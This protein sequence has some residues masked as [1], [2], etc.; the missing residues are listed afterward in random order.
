MWNPEDWAAFT[1]ALAGTDW[2]PYVEE[3]S[4]RAY[5]GNLTHTNM[6][7]GMVHIESY[8][9]KLVTDY[10]TASNGTSRITID[11]ADWAATAKRW[12]E[13]PGARRLSAWNARREEDARKAAAVAAVNAR[14]ESLAAHFVSAGLAPWS[15]LISPQSLTASAIVDAGSLRVEL[16][17]SSDRVSWEVHS[18]A[19]SPREAAAALLVLAEWLDVHMPESE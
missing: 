13:G 14:A 7:G 3:G 4:A 12:V 19:A 6:P 5:V 10:A 8:T 17:P 15:R 16:H 11:R 9:G 1:A 2:A 18:Y